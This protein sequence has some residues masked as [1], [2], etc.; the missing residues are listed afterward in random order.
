[1]A[2]KTNISGIG[3]LPTLDYFMPGVEAWFPDDVDGWVSGTLRTRNVDGD[4]VK[5]V[6]NLTSGKEVVHQGKASDLSSLP[7]LRNPRFLEATDDLTEL[8]HLNEP[9]VLNNVKLRFEQRLIYTY[10]GIVL[11]ALN[12]F[13][14]VPLYTDEVMAAYCNKRRED[15]D[16]H[17]FAVADEAFQT[18]KKEGK[19]QTIVC[20]GESGA[21][22]TVSAKFIMRYFANVDNLLKEGAA[23]GANKHGMS[24]VERAVLATN[25]ITEAF[26]NAK[27]TRNDNS[28]RF[29]K[30]TEIQLS[31]SPDGSGG[32][33]I[34]G[35][36]IRTYLL[37]RSR[38]V[39]QPPTERGYHIFYQLCAGCPAAE[40]KELALATWD[41][42][43]Y[44]NQGGEGT[45]P[46]V[47]DAAEFEETQKA[48]STIGISV[49]KQWELFRVC[50]AVLHLG[51]VEVSQNRQGEAH[52]AESDPALEHVV[53][54]LD[55]DKRLFRQ[56]I[57][58]KE[59]RARTE[60]VVTTVNGQ[61]AATSKDSIAKYLFSAIFDWIISMV[62]GNLAKDGDGTKKSFIGVLDIYG[63]EFF[64]KNSFEQFCINFANEKLQQEFNEHV[65]KLEQEEYIKEKITW[66]FIDFNDNQPCIDLIEGKLGIM[67]FLDEESRLPSGT[68]NGLITKL[69]QR[70]AGPQAKDKHPFFE[71]PRFGT[72]AFVV[73]HYAVSVQYEIDGFLEKN[74]DTYCMR[75]DGTPG[76]LG[77]RS[78]IIPHYQQTSEA[79]AVLTKT[80]DDMG[81]L[82]VA[83][84]HGWLESMKRRLQP[85]A[86]AAI[87]EYEEISGE[88]SQKQRRGGWFGFGG[89]RSA[90]TDTINDLIDFLTRIW[91]ALKTYYVE[92]TITR[93][94][95]I[96]LI[97]IVGYTAFNELMMRKNFSTYKR[98]IQLQFNE[99]KLRSWIAAHN[100]NEAMVYLEP[101]FQATKILFLPKYNVPDIETIFEV[102]ATMSAGQIRRLVSLYHA[103]DYEEP[104]S[105]EL[106][107]EIGRRTMDDPDDDV[108]L[109]LA[110]VEIMKPRPRVVE[111]LETWIPP[112]LEGSLPNLQRVLV[113]VDS[114]YVEP[115]DEFMG[116]GE[117]EDGMEAE[118]DH[119]MNGDHDDHEH[120]PED[121]DYDDELHGSGEEE[122]EHD[123][124]DHQ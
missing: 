102:G 91:K 120:E 89:T 56:W 31:P 75:P 81:Y 124:R 86:V 38:I 9:A 100:L 44:M 40:K 68:D 2:E 122:D 99:D 58:K 98:G 27:T 55:V 103:T 71:K 35:A 93:Q 118:G 20:S 18:L 15:Q 62:N 119:E 37:E 50:A 10:S 30:Y 24:E 25:P 54:L 45:I 61:V 123:E 1:M 28:S 82:L 14:N 109:N 19:N 117:G 92:D 66:S 105:Q 111:V 96:E 80:V 39:T 90:A 77:S 23:F 95:L 110:N 6:F 53:R 11:I 64:K 49:A 57:I 112:W 72:R 51:N 94:I 63:F 97:R 59:I 48:L 60:T 16:P 114:L 88:K 36:Q 33:R 73:R 76:N 26:G 104:V 29:G 79:E 101:L 83:I 67:D 78:P 87:I 32:L 85:M 70:F 22:K 65:F 84:I 116:D 41:K 106:L 12:P 8:S 115:E 47:N 113:E 7:P 74:K 43:H 34:S 69:Y 42:F 121:G 21:G 17:L 3:T 46:G 4:N 5:L 52:I 107:K 13:K 108:L